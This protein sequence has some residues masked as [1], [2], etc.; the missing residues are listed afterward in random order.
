MALR[1]GDWKDVCNML[2]QNRENDFFN[3]VAIT[4]MVRRGKSTLAKHMIKKVY[5]DFTYEKNYIGNPKHGS[6]FKQLYDSPPKS[7]CWIDEGE[8]IL[9]SELRLSKEQWWLQQLFNQF[10]SHNKTIFI[11]TPTFRRIDS[12]WRDEHITIW[13]HIY[14][15]GCGVLLKKREM[16]S[17]HDVWGLEAMRDSEMSIKSNQVSDENVLGCFDK[18]PCA[19][20]YFTFPDLP[21]DEKKE[22]EEQKKKSQMD[23]RAEFEVWE[24]MKESL[25][26]QDRGK[27]AI[28]RITAYL[29]WQNGMKYEDM[30]KY[31][32]YSKQYHIDA[33]NYFV[34]EVCT[35]EEIFN[36][37]PRTH[38]I[39][40]FVERI[41]A[42]YREKHPLA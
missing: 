24:K 7:A 17:S 3:C 13:I 32:G 34:D 26:K 9:S 11:C 22:Y 12:R 31:S 18:N 28:G 14:R 29:R 15:R 38:F 41:Q 25:D 10:A 23:L 27:M 8:K 33:E 36:I 16:V 1:Q 5:P 30:A 4:A 19:L 35:K 40:E 37:L 2:I 39:P 6:S 20:F 42:H 21:E